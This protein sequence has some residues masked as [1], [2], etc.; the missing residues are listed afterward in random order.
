MED[1][2]LL[3][4]KIGYVF[5]DKNLLKRAF[6]HISYSR[7]AENYEVL[8]FLGDALVNFLIVSLLVET[9]PNKR[10]GELSQLKSFL[11]SE[12][13]L[14]KMAKDL[15][16]DKFILL[17]KG[18]E[19]K[20]SKNNPSILCDVFE[21]FWA[22]FYLDSDKDFKLLKE[23]FE[24]HFKEKILSV[25]NSDSLKQDYKTI[26]QELTQKRW[27][28]RPT[29]KIISVEGP[30]HK[31][32][33]TIECSFKE[34]KTIGKGFSKKHAEQEAAKHMLEHLKDDKK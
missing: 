20:G 19:L 4:E 5:K 10:E 23:I 31:K 8:E 16:F 12:E 7:S 21:A 6:T 13:F 22:A 2:G 29:Y 9:F 28:E 24:R 11:I 26:L 32:S 18:E 17:S 1:F 27:R 34:L 30:E 14:S 33:F 3:E 25:I 15:G